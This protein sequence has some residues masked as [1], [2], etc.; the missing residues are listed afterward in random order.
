ML[1]S[2]QTQLIEQVT[3]IAGDSPQIYA[4]KLEK[5]GNAVDWIVAM[6]VI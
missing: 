4:A 5:V 2:L 3:Y 6:Q 1:P